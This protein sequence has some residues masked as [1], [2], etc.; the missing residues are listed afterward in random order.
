[1]TVCRGAVVVDVEVM[2]VDEADPSGAPLAEVVVVV[3]AK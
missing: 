2:N 3:S 1:M